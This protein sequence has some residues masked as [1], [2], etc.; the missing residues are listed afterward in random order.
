MSIGPPVRGSHSRIA[1]NTTSRMARASGDS[2]RRGRDG[3]AA[4]AGGG[5]SGPG[6]PAVRPGSGLA[7]SA[8]GPRNRGAS[9]REQEEVVA[10]AI[11][12]LKAHAARL[13]LRNDP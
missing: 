1:T 7:I 8:R 12:Q 10:A 2:Q 13:Q 3:T 5:M 9:A 4:A 11:Q 6:G